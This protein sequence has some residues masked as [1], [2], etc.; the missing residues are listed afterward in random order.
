M[1]VCEIPE[2][3]IAIE[4]GKKQEFENEWQSLEGISRQIARTE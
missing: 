4:L 3:P 1:A 2:N